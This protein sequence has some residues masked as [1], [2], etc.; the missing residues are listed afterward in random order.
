[1]TYFYD[2]ANN[3]IRTEFPNN[4]VE[5]RRYDDLNR[6][7]EIETLFVDPNTGIETTLSGFEYE[8]ND[9]GH[10]LSVTEATGRV[11][12]Y[13]Y[14]D[15]YRLVQETISDPNDT[16]NDERVIRYVYDNVGNRLSRDDS[17]EG[18]TSYV[19]DKNDRL[20]TEMLTVDNTVTETIIYSYD[21]NGNLIQRM[22][23][24]TETISYAWNDENRLIRV[25]Q[26]DGNVVTYAY[27]TEGVRVK[28]TVNGET[29]KYLIDNTL[30]YAQ[31]L[32]EIK[33]DDLVSS[34]V[35]GHDLISKTHGNNQLFY[36]VDGLG[37]TRALTNIGGDVTDVYTYEAFGKLISATET[38]QNSYLFAGEQFDQNLN[39]YY[40][41]QRYFE[42]N[43]GRFY[44]RDPFFG[45]LTEP[46]SL[47]KYSYV[48]ADPVNWTDPSGLFRLLTALQVATILA[49]STTV[50]YL[51][52][53][54][55]KI[56]TVSPILNSLQLMTP[57]Q[58]DKFFANY[59]HLSRELQEDDIKP[60]GEEDDQGRRC[61]A[62]HVPR[63]GG[64]AETNAYA[65]QV[66]GSL[67][68]YFGMNRQAIA[69][70]YDG[71]TPGTRSVWE[72]K[73]GYA[74]IPSNTFLTGQDSVV[75]ERMF[76]K[77]VMQ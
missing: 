4:T 5:I 42:P 52:L 2:D 8:I 7:L 50:G 54:K 70:Q 26:P 49:A 59:R 19:Y 68:D 57:A 53:P 74:H 43:T 36:H 12:S 11:V 14:D 44:S 25:E 31:V 76:E 32:E 34:Y 63:A 75:F 77:V 51:A 73:F 56:S 20:Q 55:A 35:Y 33:S 39:S 61:F 22:K 71:L 69:I 37:S 10:R 46:S 24:D 62:G 27:D 16:V 58:R 41:R 15:L 47:Q 23:N 30:L 67:S 1:M 65:T 66:T 9:I 45:F 3:L 60:E 6:S 29:T 13:V 17:V 72:A 64:N 48:G 40:L 28:E 18:L 38:A 21:E